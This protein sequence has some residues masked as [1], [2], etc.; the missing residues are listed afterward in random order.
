MLE[1][2]FPIDNS[3]FRVDFMGD[4]GIVNISE[5]VINF[6]VTEEI[7]KMTSGSI[8]L[9]DPYHVYSRQLKNG[10]TF[11]LSWG[12]KQTGINNIPA[13]T[14]NP[15]EITGSFVRT[16]LRGY[17]QSP[18]GGGDN[19]GVVTY[20]CNFYGAEM[21]SNLKD[22]FWYRTGTK[23]LVIQTVFA[24][25]GV[26]VPFINFVQQTEQLTENNAVLQNETHFRL[27]IRLAFEWRCTF[28]LA[29]NSAGQLMGLFVD[30]A[31]IDG[32]V[33]QN[34]QRLSN[35]GVAGSSK[36]FEYG[37]NSTYPN[38][39]S[40]TWKHNIGDSGLG[41]GNRIEI[42]NGR[43]VVTNYTVSGEIVTVSRLNEGRLREYIT[44]HPD[45]TDLRRDILAAN[46]LSSRIGDT[47]V[48]YFFDEVET[49]TA[50]QGLGYSANLQVMGDPLLTCPVKAT[51]GNGFPD[52]FQN[53]FNGINKFFVKKVSHSLN[54]GGYKCAI[55]IAD[56][57]TAFGSFVT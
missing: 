37:I 13:L 45:Q 50:P 20:N 17:I 7:Q 29:Y 36:L 40:Y 25:L 5:D 6:S 12:Y 33:A 1:A 24:K 42:I 35:G 8:T 34:F 57:I 41:D 30:N 47:T 56:V 52:F 14:K 18:G 4:S 32:V 28:K 16:G 3:F 53:D 55:E 23:L 43:S 38:V 22:T 51:M 39:I 26:T 54:S 31:Q 10:K 21:M 9:Y 27:L 19:G 46:S 44:T 48:R 15:T 2:F 11:L 49:S